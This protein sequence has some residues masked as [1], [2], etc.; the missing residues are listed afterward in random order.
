ME[1]NLF[2]FKQWLGCIGLALAIQVQAQN[3]SPTLKETVEEE[4]IDNILSKVQPYGSVRIGVGYAISEIGVGNNV[5]RVGITFRHAVFED[6]PGKFKV[7]GRIEFGLDLVSRDETIEF[8]PDPGQRFSQAGDAVFTRLGYVGVQYESFTLKIG[9]E[10][11][12]Y[13]Q[14]AA[15]EVDR[16]LA[17][18]GFAIGVW[19]A[20]TDGGI[21]GT[22]RANQ[23]IMLTYGKNNL[24][25]G[26]QMQARDISRASKTVD[27]Y[28]FG[29]NYSANGIGLG[30]AYNKVNDGV[31]DPAPNQALMGDEAFIMAISYYGNR[32]VGAASYAILSNHEK[33]AVI[34]E[35]FFY[36]AT[37]TELYLK[38]KFSSS[39]KWHVATGFGYLEPN[40]DQNLGDFNTIFGILELAYKFRKSSYLSTNVRLNDSNNIDG[41]GRGSNIYGLGIRF[42][43]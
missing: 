40:S 7:I 28:G 19:N 34:D 30:V 12:I 14:L 8:T 33:I 16:F 23:S 29:A 38:Y 27:T 5:P 36:D 20:G 15:S 6:D 24:K 13:Y 37:G 17:F 31:V 32:F 26:A 3:A 42:D 22:G 39:L 9:K 4:P 2:H 21:S 11:S 10:N 1:K 43:F 25:L 35:D 41:T 18:G